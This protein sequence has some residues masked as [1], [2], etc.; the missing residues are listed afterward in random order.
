MPIRVSS[1]P[2]T[3][4]SRIWFAV[5]GMDDVTGGRGVLFEVLRVG[6]DGPDKE[7]DD[8]EYGD[9]RRDMTSW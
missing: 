3:C 5:T 2:T 8:A 4:L 9:S 1:E 6:V 7:I